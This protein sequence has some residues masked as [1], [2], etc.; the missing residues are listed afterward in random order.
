MRDLDP[1]DRSLEPREVRELVQ[2][3]NSSVSICELAV[4]F[5][6]SEGGVELILEAH[7]VR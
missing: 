4:L 3:R 2:M 5:D 7:D 6:I 1:N